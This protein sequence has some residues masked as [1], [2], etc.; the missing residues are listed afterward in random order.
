MSYVT[1]CFWAI[2]IIFESKIQ[3]IINY[4]NKDLNYP[5]QSFKAE[6]GTSLIVNNKKIKTK[7]IDV[8]KLY[9]TGPMKK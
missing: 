6:N 8:E 5:I 2:V 7:F 3:K 4:E 1:Y 9:S